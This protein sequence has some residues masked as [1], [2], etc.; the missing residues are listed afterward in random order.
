MGATGD[1]LPLA[2]MAACPAPPGEVAS[3]DMRN[4][5]GNEAPGAMLTSSPLLHGP[6]FSET[7]MS[8]VD[9][10]PGTGFMMKRPTNAL[11]PERFL[12]VNSRV[13]DDTPLI[14]RR[15][16]GIRLT[17]L[18]SGDRNNSSSGITAN[19]LRCRI[20][21]RILDAIVMAGDKPLI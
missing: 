14:K 10:P 4:L 6:S 16:V 12:M 20:R 13:G 21:H 7:S 2:A 15:S 3:G 5:T 19:L 1:Q 18:P 9:R 8:W 17:S 11:L